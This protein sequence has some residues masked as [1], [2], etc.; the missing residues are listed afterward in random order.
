ML[1]GAVVLT[2]CR[3]VDLPSA[4]ALGLADGGRSPYM[5]LGFSNGMPVALSA[6]L[7][8]TANSLVGISQVTLSCGT[9]QLVTWSSPPYQAQVDLSPC[10]PFGAKSDA[11]EG[12]LDLTM[13]ASAFDADAPP[14]RTDL[15]FHLLVDA[16]IPVLTTDIPA[17]IRP[18][19]PLAFTLTSNVPLGATP[20]VT[21]ADLPATLTVDD[22][23]DPR[24]Y[25]GLLDQTPKLGIDALDGGAVTLDVLQDVER[26]VT[27]KA[28]AVAPNGN[29][30]KLTQQVQLTRV[31][32]D[33]P[34]PAPVYESGVVS[35]SPQPVDVPTAIAQGLVV[36]VVGSPGATNGFNPAV[37]AVDSGS[38]EL[39][40]PL[41]DGGYL[42][43]EL[44][45][46]GW[47]FALGDGQRG[48]TGTVFID[49]QN[50]TSA[51]TVGDGG[52]PFLSPVTRAG[53]ELCGLRDGTCRITPAE[54]T[55]MNHQGGFVPHGAYDLQ[56][57]AVNPV[58]GGI[59]ET[60][61]AT[62]GA[63]MFFGGYQTC[64]DG[65]ATYAVGTPDGGLTVAPG[66]F[67][68]EFG[69]TCRYLD[70]Y[71]V[72]PTD[73][74]D[75]VLFSHLWCEVGTSGVW[76]EF[77]ASP[78]LIDSSGQKVGRYAASSP[79]Y[80]PPLGALGTW[81]A[82][83]DLMVLEPS[84]GGTAINLYPSDSGTPTTASV[85]PGV[86]GYP[87]DLTADA[88]F[89][90][91]QD[92]VK[93]PDGVVILTGLTQYARA[94]IRLGPDLQPRW[95][96]RYSEFSLPGFLHLYADGDQGPVY[97]VDSFNLRVIAIER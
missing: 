37:Y 7:G 63:T 83:H 38:V 73:D 34:L 72:I 14:K 44:D 26:T 56:A 22:P 70:L 81:G 80:G 40:A 65:L 36:P 1:C 17:R 61:A 77:I 19:R 30:G 60:V 50:P 75:F 87:S 69:S 43:R 66:L 21:I 5:A 31:L 29:H 96:Y 59:V 20:V 11:G 51:V 18:G 46:D 85:I 89:S 49:S 2:G 13:V 28:D 15:T 47:V 8:F 95:I 84:A 97:L 54:L 64:A 23:D 27:I 71:P 42:G 91:P 10:A 82:A 41:L 24:R 35:H 62:S 92:V 16:S 93:G 78:D 86:Y 4:D 58:D 39:V 32:W 55:C 45:E 68:N 74:G 25:H 52:V 9:V 57:G 67:P 3:N 6:S 33:R 79:W 53:G 48:V 76:S 90:L 88:K 12:I 94:V